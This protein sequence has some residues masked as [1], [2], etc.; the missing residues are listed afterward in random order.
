MNFFGSEQYENCW[1]PETLVLNSV[2]QTFSTIREPAAVISLVIGIGG[3]AMVRPRLRRRH[4][5]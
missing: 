1:D 3:L 5:W 2:R 4:A